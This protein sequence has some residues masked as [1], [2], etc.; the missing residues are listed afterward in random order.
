MHR[1]IGLLIAH[2]LH[3]PPGLLNDAAQHRIS[4]AGVTG[5][6][7]GD[8]GARGADH[9]GLLQAQ[10]ERFHNGRAAL[11]LDHPDAGDPVHQ[12][13][14]LQLLEPFPHADGPH[15]PADGLD[16]PV[17][18]PPAQLLGD[19]KGD[20]LHALAGGQ[21]PDPPIQEQ[22]ASLG[23]LGRHL[24]GLIVGPRHLDDL[25]PVEGHLGPVEGH[26]PHL[27]GGGRAHQEGPQLDA[28]PGAVG[29]IRDRH[30]PGGGDH[31]LL[32]ARLPSHGDGQGG[33]SVLK[34]ARRVLAL[35]FDVKTG[36]AQHQPQVLRPQQRRASLL[37][38]HDVKILAQGEEL[39]VAPHG[40]GTLSEQPIPPLADGLQIVDHVQPVASATRTADLKAKVR[41]LMTTG[42]AAQ[43]HPEDPPARGRGLV[44]C[45]GRRADKGSPFR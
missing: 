7:G 44:G 14:G 45:A 1:P 38:R 24:L 10:A 20:G 25:G 11:R 33:L 39:P 27:V 34:G 35:I 21:A 40:K 8:A 2:R 42:R 18:R 28:G 29:G 15:P 16:I 9:P 13:H 5:G 32:Q 6:Q 12:A 19:L 30:V 17:R 31:H 23:E 43:P 26:L 41:P 4:Q 36:S 37:H 22:P 3:G